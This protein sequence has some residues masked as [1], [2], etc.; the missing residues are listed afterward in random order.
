MNNTSIY[1]KYRLKWK[2]HRFVRKTLQM[3]GKTLE[4]PETY[5][6]KTILSLEEANE[7]IEQRIRNSQPFAVARFGATELNFP[8]SANHIGW[9]TDRR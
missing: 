4:K 2:K 7:Y 1:Y 3:F 8:P 6:G 9:S 5:C